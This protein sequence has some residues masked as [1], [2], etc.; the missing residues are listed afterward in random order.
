[1]GDISQNPS[2]AALNYRVIF[3]NALETY[4]RKTKRDIRSHPLF[5]ELEACNCPDAILTVLQ[6]QIPTFDQSRSADVELTTWLKPTVNVLDALSATIGGGISLVSLRESEVK[7][8][9]ISYRCYAGI[10]A[11]W[12]DLHWDR[13]PPLSEYMHTFLRGLF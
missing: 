1:M 2:A 4:K 9:T 13:H 10:P 5:A 8:Y 3:D 11:R 6:N 12:G 7:S